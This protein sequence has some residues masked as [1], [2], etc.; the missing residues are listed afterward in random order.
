MQ[1]TKLLV[2][3]A[4]N[5]S[6]YQAHSKFSS[7]WDFLVILPSLKT[8]VNIE[9]KKTSDN[10]S[11]K[12]SN[13]SGASKQLEKH[14]IYFAEKHGY[15]LDEDWSFLK[16]A[17][18]NPRVENQSLA[19]S[20]CTK[21]IM[22]NEN[23]IGDVWH[24]IQFQEL[25]MNRESKKELRKNFLMLFRRLVSFSSVTRTSLPKNLSKSWEQIEGANIEYIVPGYTEPGS[26]C[27]ETPTFQGIR[28]MAHN[29]FKTIY[30]NPDQ[31]GLLFGRLAKRLVVF[32]S[33]FGTGKT[34]IAKEKAIR[35]ADK[36]NNGPVFFL[37]LV[38]S[39]QTG[40]PEKFRYIFDILSEDY[41]FKNTNVHFYDVNRLWSYYLSH[42]P[43]A[44]IQNVNVFDLAKYLIFRNLGAS[45]IVDEV[46]ICKDNNLEVPIYTPESINLTEKFI[47]ECINFV[48]YPNIFWVALQPNCLSDV[49]KFAKDKALSDT[50]KKLKQSL[51]LAN[52]HIANLSVNMR[53]SREIHNLEVIPDHHIKGIRGGHI[54]PHIFGVNEVRTNLGIN[55]AKPTT[56]VGAIPIVIP[57]KNVEFK[58]SL[59]NILS[60]AITLLRGQ[61]TQL[62]V[63]FLHDD[64]INSNDIRRKLSDLDCFA[65]VVSY[66]STND[67]L[68]CQDGL[69]KFLK[70][71]N[72][73]LITH[74]K[75]FRGC[76]SRNVTYICGNGENIRS[77]TARA[78]ENLVIVHK[79]GKEYGKYESKD[80]LFKNSQIK[81]FLSH[82]NLFY[83]VLNRIENWTTKII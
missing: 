76:E 63:V 62:N 67:P 34:L 44:K 27:S 54:Y 15:F 21:F 14:A 13:L 78:V 48:H 61:S 33:D 1:Y 47:L 77:S 46:P 26:S 31:I 75:Y 50:F 51:I 45:F 7:E 36:S 23:H 58:I 74:E 72:I 28:T 35:E 42:H 11:K 38:A 83:R 66:P 12:S 64:S 24:N 49:V 40:V 68:T 57:V 56:V 9:V 60:D 2:R 52:V 55:K 59:Q 81:T 32:F 65:D 43:N 25:K 8:V 80:H 17:A 69:D 5:Y 82:P 79:L 18:I 22:T 16:I 73:A 71:D 70:N 29:A 41:D 37:S 53:N 19:C 10:G 39:D 30:F 3:M 6:I 4:V 20:H